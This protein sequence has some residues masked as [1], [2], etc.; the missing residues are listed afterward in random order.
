MNRVPGPTSA[1]AGASTSVTQIRS[2]NPCF[3]GEPPNRIKPVNL[4]DGTSLHSSRILAFAQCR[5]DA[6]HHRRRD[7]MR[8]RERFVSALGKRHRA[9]RQPQRVPFAR[10]EVGRHNLEER[11]AD[12]RSKLRYMPEAWL[13][14]VTHGMPKPAAR[15]RSDAGRLPS[16]IGASERGAAETCQLQMSQSAR[17]RCI[18]RR[19]LVL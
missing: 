15:G 17:S 9:L 3:G 6:R 16:S 8:V 18:A 4:I 5:R 7:A 11:V 14:E 2:D 12:R 1:G 19:Q 13:R 10:A